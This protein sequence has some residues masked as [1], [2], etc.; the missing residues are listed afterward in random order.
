MKTKQTENIARLTN[1]EQLF[2]FVETHIAN[3]SANKYMEEFK[4]RQRLF[5][6]FH[7]NGNIDNFN[8]RI[9]IIKGTFAGNFK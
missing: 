4:A 7:C 8:N 1:I 6:L 5:T 3:T 2:S 9:L